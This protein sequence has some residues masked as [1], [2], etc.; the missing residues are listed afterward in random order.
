MA[1]QQP[2][3]NGVYSRAAAFSTWC[4]NY[5][6][7]IVSC[8]EFTLTVVESEE[9]GLRYT[10]HGYRVYTKNI[11]T[12][13]LGEVLKMKKEDG[14]ILCMRRLL[15]GA[16]FISLAVD[17]GGSVDSRAALSIGWR[18]KPKFLHWLEC[19]RGS[20]S[21]RAAGEGTIEISEAF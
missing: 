11:W 4:R 13:E 5:L 10:I 3:G 9:L 18:P 17:V 2:E 19:R 1:F 12:L 21:T 6:E 7:Q 8:K 15:E 16:A 14:N 20:Y